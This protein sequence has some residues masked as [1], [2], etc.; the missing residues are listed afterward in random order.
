MARFIRFQFVLLL[1]M[2]F[3]ISTVSA[4]EADAEEARMAHAV[5]VYYEGTNEVEF[6]QA[7]NNYRDY[8]KGKGDMGQYSICSGNTC[9][10]DV[11]PITATTR[12]PSLSVTVAITV[13]LFFVLRARWREKREE[14]QIYKNIWSDNE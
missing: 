14:R 6:Y 1:S 13:L 5:A 9:S 4:Q 2:L 10:W 3:G 8:L 7:I 11:S 12:R